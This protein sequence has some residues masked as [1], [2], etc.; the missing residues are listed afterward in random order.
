MTINFNVTATERK[1]LAKALGEMMYCEPVYAGAPT[2]AY[3]VNDYIIDKNGVIS[4]PDIITPE[5]VKCCYPA[6]MAENCS[7]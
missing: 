4:Y 5:A 7:R 6:E 1:R 2:F 3:V